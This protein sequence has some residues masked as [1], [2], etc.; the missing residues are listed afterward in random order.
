[1]YALNNVSGVDAVVVRHVTV[2][3]V[4]HP[5][6]EV[7]HHLRRD[8]ECLEQ[9]APLLY[10]HRHYDCIAVIEHNNQ[11]NYHRCVT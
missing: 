9:V 11:V 2:V 3:V 1:V 4:L 8:L 5:R 7:H 6:Q 10:T